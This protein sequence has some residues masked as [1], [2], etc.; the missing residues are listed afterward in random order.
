MSRLAFR[1]LLLPALALAG[2]CRP[3]PPPPDPRPDVLLVLVDD[4]SA[5][6]GLYGGAA[7]TP[8]LERLADR[9]RRFD[10]AYCQYPLCNPSRTSLFSGWRPERTRVWGNLR[11]PAPWVREAVL[12]QDHF[13]RHGYHTAR[14]GK[15]YHSRFESEFRWS[16]VVDT[17]PENADAVETPDWG[18]SSGDEAALPDAIAARSA[19]RI[20]TTPRSQPVFLA[21]GIMKPHAPWVVPERYLRLYPPAETRLPASVAAAPPSPHRSGAQAPIPREKWPEAVAAYRAAATFADAQIGLVLESLERSRVL[22][23]T[24]VVVAG[25]NGFHTAGHG[26]FGKA[27]LYEEAARVPLVIAAPGVVRPGA[28]TAALVELVDL[29]PTLLDLCGLP[30]VPGLDGVSLRPLLQDPAGSVK[31]AAF[32]MLKVGAARGAWVGRSVRTARYRF[33]LWPDGSEELFDHAA[34]PDELRDLAADPAHAGTRLAL[35]RRLGELPP[36]APAPAE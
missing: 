12:L 22:E 17:Y 27:T 1:T 6:I 5:D 35:R 23:R 36:V 24:I 4:L 34:D 16:E 29:Y 9:G 28:P 11:N 26:L 13:A 15:A 25:D 8:S 10:R 14:V 3:G 32:T 2:G 33:T 20:L 31:D 30:S 18:P 21:L 19:V 7:R